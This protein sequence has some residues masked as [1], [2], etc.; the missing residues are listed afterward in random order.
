MQR[1]FTNRL[2]PITVIA[3]AVVILISITGCKKQSG[4]PSARLPEL[5]TNAPTDITA[6]SASCGGLVIN[7]GG[8]STWRRGISWD[9]IS[10]PANYS[11]GNWNGGAGTGNFS[12]P[13]IG[14]TPLTK[15]YVRAWAEN[16]AGIAYGNEVSFST[17]ALVIGGKALDGIV[18]EID[19][20]GLHGLA[21][22]PT[23][24]E[25]VSW[26]NGDYVATGAV[27]P[28]NGYGN[29]GFILNAQGSGIYAASI[30][31]TYEWPLGS[32]YIWYLPSK[33]E[34]NKL[35]N[36]RNVIGGFSDGD[37]WSSTEFDTTKAWLKDFSDG[38]ETA[39]DKAIVHHVRAIRTF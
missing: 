22:A 29:T 10:N 13:M 14:L 35:Y 1:I 8:Q 38:K 27:A 6:I 15:Y 11:F 2:L 26:S 17:P 25:E 30:C 16:S 12:F 20:T 36:Q 21:C 34:L 37:Y 3:T 24:Q 9:T 32:D 23:D 19:N 4:K 5:T 18:F 31:V 39:S 7:E 28:Y 33:D